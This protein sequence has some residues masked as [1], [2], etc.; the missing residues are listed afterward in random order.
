LALSDLIAQHQQI[1]QDYNRVNQRLDGMEND[2]RV[3]DNPS[4]TRVTMKGTENAPGSLATVYWNPGSKEVYLKIQEMKALAQG[5]QYQLWAIV[6]GKPVD[7]GVFD[8][9]G[10]GM[11]K[12]KEIGVGA[13]MFAVTIEP[14]GGRNSP[15]LS[16]L[17]VAGKVEK[18]S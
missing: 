6:D 9:P 13:D 3:M 18:S 1:A 4:F 2:L 14:S 16:T 10:G 7:A 12:M 17:Q 15:T 11:V 8:F 5:Q